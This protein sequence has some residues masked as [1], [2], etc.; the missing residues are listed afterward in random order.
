MNLHSMY[1]K[2]LSIDK[3][4]VVTDHAIDRLIE[5]K[6]QIE[7]FAKALVNIKKNLCVTM[8]DCEVSGNHHR[9]AVGGI[10]V[11]IKLDKTSMRILITT[12]Y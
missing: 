7:D 12:A 6:V 11:P 3:R 2:A 10:K 1:K 5:R 4:I 9:I 8:F